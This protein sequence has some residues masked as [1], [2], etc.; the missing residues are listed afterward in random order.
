MTWRSIPLLAGLFEGDDS[1]SITQVRSKYSPLRVFQDIEETITVS[2]LRS[3]VSCS[4]GEQMAL[5]TSLTS[6]MAGDDEIN[7]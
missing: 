6:V 7:S 4:R 5:A 1:G 3:T 2:Q